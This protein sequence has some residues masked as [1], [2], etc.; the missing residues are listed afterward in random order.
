MHPKSLD[1]PFT[2]SCPPKKKERRKDR[3]RERD[4]EKE[5]RK[6]R[7]KERRKKKATMGLLRPGAVVSSF[8]LKIPVCKGPYK[9]FI[10]PIELDNKLNP[11]RS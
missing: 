1:T 2:D 10:D 7:E 3:E 8:I 9:M 6:E 5:G 11:C 4:R